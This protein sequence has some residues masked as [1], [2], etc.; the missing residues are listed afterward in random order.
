MGRWLGTIEFPDGTRRYATYSTVVECLLP[1]LYAE[2]VPNGGTF[3]DGSACYRAE[4]IGEPEP[5]W[6]DTARAALD[7]LVPIVI[8]TE[9][10]QVTWHALFCP[11]RAVI[12]G[13]MSPHHLDTLQQR[14]ELVADDAGVRHLRPAGAE[15]AAAQRSN[16]VCGQAVPGRPQPFHTPFRSDGV[17]GYEYVPGTDLYARWPHGDVCRECLVSQLSA[18]D[19]VPTLGSG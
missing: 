1:P 18:V 4:V 11:R 2:M 13:P 9:P 5:A 17:N 10:D 14:F 19:D 3:P 7:E 16:A 6:P 8:S 12:L 15:V